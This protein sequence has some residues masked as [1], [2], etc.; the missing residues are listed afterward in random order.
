MSG[1][2][3]QETVRSWMVSSITGG[4]LSMM[5]YLPLKVFLLSQLSLTKKLISILQS[6]AFAGIEGNGPFTKF[7]EPFSPEEVL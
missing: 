6:Q 7:P 3:K 4:T 1:M 2:L 5:R